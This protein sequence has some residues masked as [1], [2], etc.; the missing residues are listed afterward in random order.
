MTGEFNLSLKN[1]LIEEKISVQILEKSESE[2]WLEFPNE[3]IILMIILNEQT[4]EIYYDIFLPKRDLH[5]H[6]RSLH[7]IESFESDLESNG[8][9]E[10]EKHIENSWLIVD[11]IKIWVGENGFQLIEKI[12]L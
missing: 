7:D 11:F 8:L 4:H 12:L 3:S 1:F 10:M 2:L 5:L 9:W 6:E